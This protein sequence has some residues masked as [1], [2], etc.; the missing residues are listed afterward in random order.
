MLSDPRLYRPLNRL[1]AQL[2]RIE[3]AAQVAEDYNDPRSTARGSGGGAGG[4]GRQQA[5][6]MVKRLATL[7]DGA[8]TELKKTADSVEKKIQGG[9]VHEGRPEAVT[10]VGGMKVYATAGRVRSQTEAREM[11]KMV[12]KARRLGAID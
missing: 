11:Q 10:T 6:A 1:K 7:I 2:E 5:E 12:D 8:A 4:P 9:H 3:Q